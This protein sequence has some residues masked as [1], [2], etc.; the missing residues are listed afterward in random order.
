MNHIGRQDANHNG[1]DDMTIEK[2]EEMIKEIEVNRAYIDMFSCEED[3]TSKEMVLELER[4]NSSIRKEL[5][6]CG[7][8][9]V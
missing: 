9:A 1:E 7:V 2:M 5:A 6:S 3:E 4:S 8:M